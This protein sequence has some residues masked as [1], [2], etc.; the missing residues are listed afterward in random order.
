M[1]ALRRIPNPQIGLARVDG[2]W[3]EPLW[4]VNRV[5]FRTAAGVLLYLLVAV[6]SA[7]ANETNSGFYVG[8][9]LG[10]S[11]GP[12]LNST[13]TNTGIPTNCDQWLKPVVIDGV[14]LPLPADQCQ[15]R[16][17]PANANAFALGSG[18]LAGIA[19][20]YAGEGPFRF[21]AE[22]FHYR[23]G[24]DKVDLVVPGDPKQKEFSVRE[25]EIGDLRADNL[26]VN[27]YYDFAGLAGSGLRPYIGIG[28]GASHVG[29]DY[30][31]TSIRRGVDALLALEP[32]RHPD[33]ANKVS[34][35]SA[36]LSDRLWSYQLIVG[37]DYPL[38]R[39]RVVTGKLRYGRAL[40]DFVDTGNPWRSLRGHE[41]TVAPGG[42][43][44]HY[45]IAIPRPSFWVLSIGLKFS[46]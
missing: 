14:Q 21:E 4:P 27:V 15:P 31:A 34:H 12:A 40:Q 42:A 18:P 5:A 23:R 36:S 37:V 13:R 30:S 39:G 46:L 32:P 16:E 22:V 24:G 10:R 20:G 29:I 8:I 41:S 28:A 6:P 7:S 44:V 38:A 35:A 19:V 26:F 33:A 3:S 43:P 25:E 2:G 45:G 11:A 17:L 1:V 9:E